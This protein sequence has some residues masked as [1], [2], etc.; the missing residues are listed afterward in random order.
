MRPKKKTDD[1]PVPVDTGAMTPLLR[2]EERVERVP[3]TAEQAKERMAVAAGMIQEAAILAMEHA[4]LAAKAKARKQA[5]EAKQN[6]SNRIVLDAQGGTMAAPYAVIVERHPTHPTEMVVWR[7]PDGASAQELL[8]ATRPTDRDLF[9]W[10]EEQ[11]CVQVEIRAMTPG[12]LKT[13]E[14]VDQLQLPLGVEIVEV[15]PSP[16]KDDGK[17]SDAGVKK[18][19]PQPLCPFVLEEAVE[20]IGDRTCGVPGVRRHRG[21]CEVHVEE[22]GGGGMLRGGDAVHHLARKVSREAAHKGALIGRVD[23]AA[24]TETADL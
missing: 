6:E 12:E 11:G 8:E 3:I 13:R 14:S 1:T 20:P 18:A 15:A 10:R 5:A 21:F 24:I 2:V 22:L 7:P 16:E 17:A 23:A 4:D 9:D 19:S